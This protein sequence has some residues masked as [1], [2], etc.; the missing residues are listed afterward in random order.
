VLLLALRIPF[1][2]QHPHHNT[3][4]P[5]PKKTLDQKQKVDR[6]T[7]HNARL[8]LTPLTA[9]VRGNFLEMPFADGSFDAAYAIEATCHA[10]KLEQVY[11]EV[12]RVLKPGGLFLSYEWVA[13]KAFDASDAD[14]VRVIDEI[15]FGNGLPEMRTYKQAEAAGAAAGFELVASID[16]AVASAGALPWYGR[17]EELEWQNRVS[18]AIVTA[19]HTVG[20]APKGLK[21]VHSMLVEVSRSLVQGGRTG[22]F[23]PMH[24]LVFRKK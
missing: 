23:S 21:Q 17:L 16:L 7:A 2:H 5:P 3:L 18:H 4:T 6:A 22:V 11:S 24:M 20:L 12:R 15:N 9:V 1:N 8:G 19:V 14:H 13:T 10:D